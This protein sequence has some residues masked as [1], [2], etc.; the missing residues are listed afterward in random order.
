MAVFRSSSAA[1]VLSAEDLMCLR[2]AD[3][4]L[5]GVI[6]GPDQC[7]TTTNGENHVDLPL[8]RVGGGGS[9]LH[10][11]SGIKT[12]GIDLDM[13]EFEERKEGGFNGGKERTETLL[14][15]RWVAGAST[16]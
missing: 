8:V 3:I 2:R 1:S 15:A 11:S 14:M 12:K 7:R 9:L 10:K 16:G 13:G 5:D 6:G 4:V